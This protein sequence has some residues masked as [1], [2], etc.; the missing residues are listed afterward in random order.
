M[1]YGAAAEYKPLVL[2]VAAADTT[3]AAAAAAAA[4][5]DPASVQGSGGDAEAHLPPWRRQLEAA[6]GTA[7]A[8]RP[9]PKPGDPDALTLRGPASSRA[10]NGMQGSCG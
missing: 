2:P 8:G 9:G 4:G 10:R 6:W 5:G 1:A 7:A 3:A